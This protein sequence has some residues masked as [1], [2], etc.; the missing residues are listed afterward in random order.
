[1]K[2]LQRHALVLAG[3][4]LSFQACAGQGLLV[5]E[6]PYTAFESHLNV[7][8]QNFAIAQDR[9]S[10]VY[11]GN[12]DGVITFD[13]ERWRLI[14][15]PNHELVRSLAY[16]GRNRVYVGGYNEFGYI[17]HNAA[18]QPVYHDLL[19]AFRKLVKDPK[20]QDVW[21]VKVTP[22]GVFFGTLKAVFFYDPGNGQVRAWHYPGHFGAMANYDGSVVL[23]FRG[24]GLKIY[25][26]GKWTLLPGSAAFKR[27]VYSLVPLGSGGLLALSADGGWR[28]YIDGEAKPFTVPAGFPESSHF[29]AGKSL[30]DHTLVLA[31]DNGSLYLLSADGR[32]DKQVHLTDGSLPGL[33]KANDG[34]V[35]AIGDR[36]LF[37]V[38]WPTA[39]TVVKEQRGL[40]GTLSKAVN[41]NGGWYILSGSGV[42]RA[43]AGGNGKLPGLI[44]L[45]WTNHS[46][47]DMLPLGKHHALLAESYTVMEIN[48]DVARPLT[49]KNLY[50]RILVHSRFHKNRIYVGTESGL[51]ILVKRHRKWRVTLDDEN[52][53]GLDVNSIVEEAPDELWIGSE[54][55]G[56]R[57]IKLGKNGQRILAQ[58]KYGAAEGITYGA[59][60]PGGDIAMLPRGKLVVSTQAGEFLWTGKR[61][62]SYGADG[63]ESLRKPGEWFTFNVHGNEIWATSDNRIYRWD[64]RRDRWIHQPISQFRHGAIQDLEFLGNGGVMVVTTNAL[65]HYTPRNYD[66]PL[67]SPHVLLRGV[68]LVRHDGTK[69]FL[70]LGLSRRLQLHEGGFSLSFRFALPDYTGHDSALFRARLAGIENRLSSWSADSS[71]TYSQLGAGRYRFELVGRDAQGNITK[72]QPFAFDILP[73]W[74]ESGWAWAMWIFSAA[75]TTILLAAWFVRFRTRQLAADKVRLEGMVEERTAELQRANNRLQTMVNIDSLTEIPN[76]RRMDDYLDQVWSH[77]LDAQRPLS[78]LVIDVDHFKQYNDRYGHLAGDKLLRKLV[79]VLGHCL[80]RSEDLLARYGGEEFLVVLPGAAAEMA[81]NL[82][83]RM[84]KEVESSDLDITISVGVATC[85]PDADQAV[86]M[87]VHQAD[88]ALY[89]AKAAGRNKTIP[90]GSSRPNEAKPG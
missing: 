16:D 83:E 26:H 14:P 46:A 72:I 20:F 71:Y 49:R 1:M 61:F 64:S 82:G 2:I 24:E 21:D 7:F 41:W 15:L 69:E 90:A 60:V 17:E 19:P 58:E 52:M 59:G 51:A 9:N 54:R 28:E 63:L 55:G 31:A 75:V 40:A 56:V 23:Q 87:L 45:P 81:Y 74:Y 43:A 4:A 73:P 68:E 53:N 48:G 79:T 47:W 13:G 25:R 10:I 76:R 44:R 65:L 89:C 57:S 29:F 32:H 77:C 39:W 30:N 8:P 67:R 62:R 66:Q 3:L 11:I 35:L 27:L 86:T 33:I 80:R 12:Y 36:E 50:P 84:R 5:G 38:Q 37:H 22:Q 88:E 70:P 42:F 34:G 6:P 18:G 78:V 85:T